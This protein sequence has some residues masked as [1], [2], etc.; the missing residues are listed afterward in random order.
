[1]KLLR[2]GPFGQERPGMLDEDGVIRDLSRH[3]ADISAETLVPAQLA[4]LAAIPIG[5]EQ[6]QCVIAWRH[7]GEEVT[8]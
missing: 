1:M 8:S 3:V 2:Y 4:R 7:R 5:G 6:R